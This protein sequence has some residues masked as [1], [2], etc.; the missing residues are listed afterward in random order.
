MLRGTSLIFDLVNGRTLA[1]TPKKPPF[2]S[3]I[4]QP[5]TA[6]GVLRA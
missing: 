2:L 4:W 3:Q 5:V 1:V 6:H